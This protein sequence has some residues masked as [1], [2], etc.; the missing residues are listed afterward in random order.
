MD[1][2]T[3][4]VNPGTGPVL[5]RRTALIGA[6]TAA[7]LA[8]LGLPAATAR[9]G[10][11]RISPRTDHPRLWITADDLPRL[12]S[13]A[14]DDNPIWRDGLVVMAGVHADR[15]DNGDL[16]GGDGGT[17]AYEA[18]CTEVAAEVFAFMSLVHPDEGA[19]EDFADRARTLLMAVID[20]A[21]KGAAE[22]EPFRDPAF[23][24]RDR[25]RWSGEAFPLI[26]DWIYPSLSADDK[27]T[28]RAVFLRWCDENTHADTTTNNHPEPI[29]LTDD[30]ALLADPTLLRWAGNNYFT[31]HMRNI[32][33]MALAIDAGDDPDGELRAYLDQATGAWLYMADALLRG[34]ARG[35]LA[36]EGYEYSQQAVAYVVQFLLALRTSG[37]ADPATHGPQVVL[38][39]T[40]FYD[41]M[42]PA[43]L[44][45]LSPRTVG[46]EGFEW[47]GQVSQ[48]VWYGD[49]ETYWGP[50][51]IGVFGPLAL[52]DAI[53]GNAARLEALLWLQTYTPPGGEDL[54]V[55]LRVAEALE[56]SLAG[57][58]YFL[59]FD[60]EAPAPADP[61]PGIPL[62]HFADGLGRQ[63]ARTGWDEDAAVFTWALGW[64]SVDH[65]QCDGNQVEFYRGGEWL[66]KARV[67]YDFSNSASDY[68]NTLS[69]ENDPLPYAGT[70]DFTEILSA[71]G[72]QW[73]LVP[74]ADPEI[75]ARSVTDDYVYALG[76]ATGLYN[77]RYLDVNDVAHASRS[78]VWLKP[79]HIVLY[80]RAET[81]ADGRYKRFWLNG[82]APFEIDG[83]VATMTSAS[84]QQL[85]VT[86]LLPDDAEFT[87]A[88][89][90]EEDVPAIGEPM[91]FR[92]RVEAPG[93]PAVARFLHVLQ[94]VDPDAD[95]DKAVAVVSDDDA[96]AGAVV[97]G[98]A[99]LFP[100]DLGGN[101]DGV[102][103]TVPGGTGRLLVTGLA[104]G[105]DYDVTTEEDGDDLTVTVTAGGDLT[106]DD[107][108]VL[109]AE[110]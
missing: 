44:H 94:G 69:L 8:G 13:W 81:G 30:P 37:E 100:V 31:A 107:G 54:L 104:A 24:V 18:Y 53:T 14:H 90:P 10:D 62:D 42:I 60:P 86:T 34:D 43:Y 40:P 3:V 98:T 22:G 19:R 64:N 49:G 20:E 26:V 50:D 77:S 48:P 68:H 46:I 28:I 99:V 59:L 91:A 57:V 6:G 63:L 38:D 25:S 51:F 41:E 29:G 67:G 97:G 106:A 27:A 32:G 109:M 1:H 85:V 93:G 74:S 58:L 47:L 2:E 79:D 84:G 39:D 80:D 9:A 83:A 108:G 89:A 73:A 16:P 15:M 23:S 33:M 78:V 70:G 35:G 45:S 11:T 103:V 71:R 17:V 95:A 12:R 61:R 65:Q 66:T 52:H 4:T 96:F 105:G 102:T 101:V 56:F 55:S 36:A 88:A 72:S 92:L 82:P 5:S 75:V 110:L 21:V 7:A 87:A 76:D